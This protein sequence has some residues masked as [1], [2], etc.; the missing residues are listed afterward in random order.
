MMND[1]MF[2]NISSNIV[3]GNLET[4]LEI[5]NSIYD[6]AK[7]IT[8]PT[9]KLINLVSII[10]MEVEFGLDVQNGNNVPMVRRIH[11]I[12]S[13]YTCTIKNYEKLLLNIYHGED[14]IY[15]IIKEY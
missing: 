7:P 15:L 6:F 1:E 13:D 10:N 5:F 12:N 2:I 14:L 3:D 9:S 11:I 8:H 4:I